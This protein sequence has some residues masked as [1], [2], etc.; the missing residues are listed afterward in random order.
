MIKRQALQPHAPKHQLFVHLSK[1]I[2]FFF[3][4]ISENILKVNTKLTEHQDIN[5]KI[6]HCT[7]FSNSTTEDLLSV[8]PVQSDVCFQLLDLPDINL[9]FIFSLQSH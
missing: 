5:L 1:L 4:S 2:F 3:K 6:H 9:C 7:C 8:L